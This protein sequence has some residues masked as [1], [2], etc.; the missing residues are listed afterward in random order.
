MEVAKEAEEAMMKGVPNPSNF[1]VRFQL[2]LG[3]SNQPT[4]WMWMIEARWINQI[5]IV[6]IFIIALILLGKYGS[7]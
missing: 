1:E 5:Y 4:D 3:S 6:S 7:Y 2:R